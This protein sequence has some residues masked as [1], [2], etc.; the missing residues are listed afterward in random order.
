[1]RKACEAG[2]YNALQFAVFNE[3]HGRRVPHE[4]H[5]EPW[6]NGVVVARGKRLCPKSEEKQIRAFDTNHI[7]NYPQY[8]DRYSKDEILFSQGREQG[9]QQG[10]DRK[11]MN[12][13]EYDKKPVR[14][15]VRY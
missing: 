12:D 7:E 3:P 1:M 9:D 6:E 5:S 11:K 4:Y 13:P 8:G 15:Q 14:K 2:F 10:S